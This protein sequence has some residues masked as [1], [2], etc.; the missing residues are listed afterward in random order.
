MLH[1]LVFLVLKFS[2]KLGSM[3]SAVEAVSGGIS[4]YLLDGLHILFIVRGAPERIAFRSDEFNRLMEIEMILPVA[5]P[6]SNDPDARD[7]KENPFCTKND[8]VSNFSCL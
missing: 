4:Y 2:L 5:D 6:L 1:Q 8:P 3:S 7:E